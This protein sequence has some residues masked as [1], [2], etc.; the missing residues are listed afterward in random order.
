MLH[1]LNVDKYAKQSRAEGT[2]LND[3]YSASGM[4]FGAIAIYT[5]SNSEVCTSLS[6][7]EFAIVQDTAEEQPKMPAAALRNAGDVIVDENSNFDQDDEDDLMQ[8]D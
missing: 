5:C 1:V 8:D 6:L 3:W 7:E 2:Q 4:D